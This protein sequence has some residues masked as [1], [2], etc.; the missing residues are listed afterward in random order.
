[1]ATQ[2]LTAAKV[3]SIKEPGRYGDGGR[4]SFGLSFLVR[5]AKHGGISKNWQQRY[6]KDGKYSSR[7]LGTYPEVS[8][9]QA[10]ALAASFALQGQPMLVRSIHGATDEQLAER[11]AP[12]RHELKAAKT[13]EPMTAEV[14]VDRELR[15]PTF[16]Q[17]FIET[18][19]VRARG[20]AEGSKN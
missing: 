4:G 7:G 3:N 1:M 9:E 11:M 8:L 5:T 2:K 13:F 20:Y 18:V 17:T 10:R 12:V 16:R 14:A 15:L 6:R 19:E